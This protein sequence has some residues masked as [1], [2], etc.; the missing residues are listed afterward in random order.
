[1]VPG[2]STYRP[3]MYGI[4]YQPVYMPYYR[5]LATT[6]ADVSPGFMTASREPP[7]DAPC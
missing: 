7:A 4:A 3:C 6:L 2:T 5:T 1:M